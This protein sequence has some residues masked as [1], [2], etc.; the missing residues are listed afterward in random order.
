MGRQAPSCSSWQL[1]LVHLRLCKEDLFT[2]LL[3]C[4]YVHCLTEVVALK[5][6]EKLYSTMHELMHQHESGLLGHTKPANQLA[7]NVEEPAMASRSLD[8]SFV[9]SASSGHCFA[10]TLVHLVRPMS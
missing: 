2:L 6:A 1:I 10:M 4:G 3:S 5:V 9:R 8:F 7:A